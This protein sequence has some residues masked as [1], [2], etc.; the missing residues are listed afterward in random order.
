MSARL[1]P[2]DWT[3]FA[4]AFI[5][6][7]IEIALA[8]RWT[9]YIVSERW[10][11]WKKDMNIYYSY[12]TVV[13]S[14]MWLFMYAAGGASFFLWW[15]NAQAHV[16]Y[17]GFAAGM[18]LYFATAVL[19]L[20]WPGIFLN[21]PKW[22]PFGVVVIAAAF[23]SSLGGLIVVAI[24][25]FRHTGSAVSLIGAFVLLLVYA[26]ILCF[27]FVTLI[28]MSWY[29]EYVTEGEKGIAARM[30][31]LIRGLTGGLVGTPWAGV[32]VPSVGINGTQ[33][34][35]TPHPQVVPHAT[36]M[37]MYPTGASAKI[38]QVIQSTHATIPYNRAPLTAIN[39]SGRM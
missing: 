5:P 21:G 20:L 1:V 10:S 9:S 11:Q 4:V 12:S 15:R 30:S 22:W 32:R 3:M 36:T 18:G 14:Y 2:D 6:F 29:R 17:G 24:N 31:A 39:R 25:A 7:L 26:I 19:S 35:G 8:F 34:S 33:F 23:A 16:G 13:G 38:N 27:T 28:I 37:P